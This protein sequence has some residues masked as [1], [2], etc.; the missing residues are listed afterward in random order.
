MALNTT[1][2][3]KNKFESIRIDMEYKVWH[4]IPYI[5]IRGSILKKIKTKNNYRI[6]RFQSISDE[7]QNSKDEEKEQSA[8]FHAYLLEQCY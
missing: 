7:V 6:V 2:R 3:F 5:I 1:R 8:L 4:N